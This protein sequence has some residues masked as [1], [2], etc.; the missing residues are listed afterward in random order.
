MP[1]QQLEECVGPSQEIE[2]PDVMAAR[3][4]EA[5]T[6]TAIFDRIAEARHD[7]AQ[8]MALSQSVAR[9]TGSLDG[10]DRVQRLA[11][12]RAHTDIY[13]RVADQSRILEQQRLLTHCIALEMDRGSV[14]W[15]ELAAH[16]GA[17]ESAV[18]WAHACGQPWPEIEILH[19]SPAGQALIEIHRQRERLQ[20]EFEALT[21]DIARRREQLTAALPVSSC[22]PAQAGG[23]LPQP[24]PEGKLEEPKKTVA[25]AADDRRSK[26]E[27]K[28][29]AQRGHF[30]GAKRKL[31]QARDRDLE[32]HHELRKF[33]NL[34][35]RAGD[36]EDSI[37]IV[38]FGALKG[39][40][41]LSD[42]AQKMSVVWDRMNEAERACQKTERQLASL[43]LSPAV[44]HV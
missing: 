14:A 1:T 38:S 5:S 3:M 16:L 11:L 28:L 12:I 44:I 39:Y 7:Q 34:R 40:S 29:E 30:E 13:V 36:F 8:A 37:D 27:A 43:P 23:Q 10:I 35:C 41:N 25:L 33:L 26:L 20:A 31:N 24:Q 22:G 32:T 42:K 9:G 19:E 21:A 4:M 15:T 2:S 6:A 18:R 17:S